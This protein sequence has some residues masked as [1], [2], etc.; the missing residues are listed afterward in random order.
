MLQ[1]VKSTAAIL[2]GFAF[3]II[4]FGNIVIV[5]QTSVSGT[6]TADTNEKLDREGNKRESEIHLNLERKRDRGRSMHGQG[7]KFSDLRGLTRENSQNG[8]VRFSLVREAGTF[9]FDGTFTN[10]KGSGNFVFTPDQGFFSSMKAKGFDFAKDDDDNDRNFDERAMSAALINVTSSLA[11]DLLSANFGKL[12]ADDL[13]KAAIFKIDSKFMAEMK[14][15]G[16]PDLKMEE[17]VKAR[18]FKIDADYVKQVHEM[19]FSEKGFESLV[20]FRIF[21]VTPEFLSELKA[22]G[23]KDLDSEDIVKCRIFKID[24]EFV[25]KAK[26]ENPN[27][28]IEELVKMK[29]FG[30]KNRTEI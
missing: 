8:T 17:L 27:V 3:I 20:K 9:E 23:L 21:K 22:A 24:A 16:F 4:V 7:Y 13:F 28:T 12:D 6:W 10:G 30:K 29:I 11:D 15:T 25:R 26:T 19:G 2:V 1:R 18:I 5:A 14:A